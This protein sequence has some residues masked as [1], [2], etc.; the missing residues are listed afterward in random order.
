MCAS[1]T[2]LIAPRALNHIL[3]LFFSSKILLS[4]KQQLLRTILGQT[5]H[6]RGWPCRKSSFKIQKVKSNIYYKNSRERS[7]QKPLQVA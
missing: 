2:P 5:N 3:R 7:A 4:H 1:K 6:A